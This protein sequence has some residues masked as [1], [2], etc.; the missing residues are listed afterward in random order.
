MRGRRGALSL[1]NIRSEKMITED[2][3]ELMHGVNFSPLK[4]IIYIS[5]PKGCTCGCYGGD[6]EPCGFCESLYYHFPSAGLSHAMGQAVCGTP[7]EFYDWYY[8]WMLCA[9]DQPED[10]EIVESIFKNDNRVFDDR[11]QIFIF[12]FKTTYYDYIESKIPEDW[13]P[14]WISD[15]IRLDETTVKKLIKILIED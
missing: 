8:Q 10:E 3:I 4:N 14:R 1:S 6:Q 15:L 9:K 7:D 5:F 13:V 11:K 12:K 2:E